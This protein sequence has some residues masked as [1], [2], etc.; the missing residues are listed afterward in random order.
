MSFV[1][2]RP[3]SVEDVRELERQGELP[4][5]LFFWGHTAKPTA[6]D[7][8]TACLSQWWP[9]RFTVDG[10]EYPSAESFMMVHKARLFGDEQTAERILAVSRPQE[11][12]ALGRKVRG[13]DEGVWGGQRYRI[14]VE[15]NTAKFGQD[16]ALRDYLLRTGDQILV[17]ASPFDRVWGI[18]L[19]ADDERAHRASTWRGSNLLGFALMDVR[20]ALNGA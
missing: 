2:Q 18:G 17:E 10:V 5:F 14:V 7:L 8:G 4:R 16:L 13:F 9:A 1:G 15:G 3:R 6:V 11:A 20:E 19:L 12:K